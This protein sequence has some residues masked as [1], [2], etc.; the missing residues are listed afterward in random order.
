L[1]N[2]RLCIVLA[3][4]KD[5]LM[6][7]VFDRISQ[8]APKDID[9]CVV[10]SGKYSKEICSVCE[11]NSW[12][13][14]STKRNNV[15]LAQNIAIYLHPNAGYIYKLDEDVFIT[16][17]YFDNML[18]AYIHAKEHSLY[19]PGVIAP[20]IPVN[21]YG[22]IRILE[23][24][25][26]A[27][28]YNIRFEQV[29]YSSNM[30]RRIMYDSEVSKFM[31]GEPISL[32]DGTICIIPSIDDLNHR[33]MMDEL[34]EFPCPVR[35]SIGAVMFERQLWEDMTMFRVGRGN[36]LGGDEVY[37][38]EFCCNYSRPLMVSENVVV[39]HLA[40]GPQNEEMKEYFMAH[41]EKF[42]FCKSM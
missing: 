8:F 20:L 13:Y 1:K 41:T 12:S 22:H 11:A 24:L 35:F 38:C 25:G 33:F 37:L 34:R 10:T 27:D 23:K 16:E 7:V 39:G 36:Y 19:N 15:A 9:I 14:L 18:R 42:T 31:W 32:E 5:Y 17:N 4:Y 29:K 21:G 30:D 40:F 26:L 28:V 2:V 3:G 6:P